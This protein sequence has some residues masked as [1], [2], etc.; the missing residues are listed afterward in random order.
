MKFVFYNL[1]L[2]YIELNFDIQ[3]KATNILENFICLLKK[4]YYKVGDYRTNLIFYKK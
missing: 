2:K 3:L 1:V 4:K